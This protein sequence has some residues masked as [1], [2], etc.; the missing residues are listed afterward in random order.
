MDSDDS[1]D[2]GLGL[3]GGGCQLANQIKPLEAFISALPTCHLMIVG[4]DYSGSGAEETCFCPCHRPQMSNWRTL[5]SVSIGEGECKGNGRFKKPNQ[6]IAHL[7]SMK[8]CRFHEYALKFLEELYD[9]WYP[10][11]LKHK[12]L[13]IDN[14][15]D[16]NKAEAWEK[17]LREK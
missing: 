6:L 1:E 17:R 3:G 7:K 2:F 8:N 15:D 12:G 13:Y 14:T 10:N 9:N 16:Y 4:F 5:A 11:H